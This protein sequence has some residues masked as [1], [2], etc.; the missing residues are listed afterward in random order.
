M[1]HAIISVAEQVETDLFS[2]YATFTTT[3]VG[4]AATPLTSA[5]IGSAET[6][7]YNAKVYGDKYLA[8]CPASYDVVRALPEF[9]NQYQIG[10]DQNALA[11]GVLGQIKGFNVF[12]SQLAPT[13][14]A[15]SPAVTTQY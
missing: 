12:R 11:T 1:E 15:G 14:T 7:L 10:N 13:V 6:A 4:T 5:V 9:V 2:Q 8:L 3:A